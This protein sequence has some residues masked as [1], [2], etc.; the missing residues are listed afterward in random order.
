MIHLILWTSKLVDV[1]RLKSLGVPDAEVTFLTETPSLGA[2]SLG[3]CIYFVTFSKTVN[4]RIGLEG[5]IEVDEVNG[6]FFL[7][8]T[9][10]HRIIVFASN[11]EILDHIRSYPGFEDGEFESSKIMRRAALLYDDAED[12]MYLLTWRYVP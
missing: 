12:S 7:S 6:L 8:D 5:C 2:E 10:H 4:A 3:I 9:N 11:G 1:K